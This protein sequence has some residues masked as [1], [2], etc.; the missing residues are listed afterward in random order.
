MTRKQRAQRRALIVRRVHAILDDGAPPEV[1]EAS[2]AVEQLEVPDDAFE[3]RARAGA[4][5]T[6][7]HSGLVGD[8]G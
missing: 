5:W 3:Q 2:A 1:G 4:A 7:R 8:M 6:A